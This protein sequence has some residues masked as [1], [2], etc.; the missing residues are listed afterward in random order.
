M[1]E[2]VAPKRYNLC[3][4]WRTLVS[5]KYIIIIFEKC[6]LHSIGIWN[7]QQNQNGDTGY[8]NPPNFARN[9]TAMLL[10]E[11][12]SQYINITTEYYRRKIDIVRYE[13]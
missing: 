7:D 5:S 1:R 8:C 9:A 4:P 11:D 12:A 2:A 10:D 3:T 6:C 13:G